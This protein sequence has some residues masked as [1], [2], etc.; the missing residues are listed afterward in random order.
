MKQLDVSGVIIFI[1][2]LKCSR[3][4]LC[5]WGQKNESVSTSDFIGQWRWH[6]ITNGVEG[7]CCGSKIRSWFAPCRTKDIRL[8]ML[9][10]KASSGGWKRRCSIFGTGEQQQLSSSFRYSTPTFAG[11]TKNGLKSPLA[12]AVHW[13]PRESRING[14]KQF[15]FFPHSPAPQR[16]VSRVKVKYKT[17][18]SPLNRTKLQEKDKY[19]ER[20]K[21]A[22]NWSHG[23]TFGDY[24]LGLLSHVPNR[25]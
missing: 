3:R 24:K 15:K 12:L 18:Q 14:I 5:W 4:T 17:F 25:S 13:I 2:S 1:N 6:S 10:V 19:P 20:G 22:P 9:H 16:Q 23:L 8:T 11:T 21:H 7:G